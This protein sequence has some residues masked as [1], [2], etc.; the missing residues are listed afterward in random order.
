MERSNNT[1][2]AT[3]ALTFKVR[4]DVREYSG[5]Q[6]AVT[7]SESPKY[8]L[9][10]YLGVSR[11]LNKDL[12]ELDF[13]KVLDKGDLVTSNS[14]LVNSCLQIYGPLPFC[15][16]INPPKKKAGGRC[17]TISSML[18]TRLSETPI[19]WPIHSHICFVAFRIDE[20]RSWDIAL[21]VVQ[22]RD[23]TMPNH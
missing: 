16:Q 12:H 18:A 1:V 20:P 9:G 5:Q 17:I 2:H 13:S 11:G 7:S 8:H 15:F 6:G 19:A 22:K 4:V 10:V 14:S 23:S 3:I 21:V